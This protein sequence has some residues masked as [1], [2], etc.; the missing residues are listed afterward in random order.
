M[1]PET[2]E[3]ISVN[4]DNKQI[5]EMYNNLSVK[6]HQEIN[7]FFKKTGIHHFMVEKSDFI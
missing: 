5:Q 6:K 7:N 4:T 2:F 3:V 1:D